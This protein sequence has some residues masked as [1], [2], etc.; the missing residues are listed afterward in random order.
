MKESK[1]CWSRVV[2]L[3]AAC[4]ALAASPCTRALTF[5]WNYRFLDGAYVEG[6]LEADWGSVYLNNVS[7][8]TW[9]Y[10][11]A[12]N[13]IINGSFV[14][15]DWLDAFGPQLVPVN[16]GVDGLRLFL[17]T[18]TNESYEYNFGCTDSYASVAFLGDDGEQFTQVEMGRD[19]WTLIRP[20]GVPERGS[21][22]TLLGS[23]LAGLDVVRRLVRRRVEAGDVS[24]DVDVA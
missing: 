15:A 7:F 2:W 24:G 12:D 18:D 14:E 5:G 23:A 19:G 17:F 16:G 10:H 3:A 13:A 6:T 11:S 22:L 4:I 9:T 20:P 1:R 8:A 21:S